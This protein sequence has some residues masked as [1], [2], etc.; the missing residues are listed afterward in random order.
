[1]RI[2]LHHY[3][4]SDAETEIFAELHRLRKLTEKIIMDQ[5]EFDAQVAQIK[6]DL[7]ATN[8]EIAAIKQKVA[9]FIASHPGLDVSALAGIVSEAD[10]LPAAVD[11]IGTAIP[12]NPPA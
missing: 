6:T 12:E 3:H 9:D 10:A 1:M 8:T 7:D 11:D 5:Q 2:N 4:H